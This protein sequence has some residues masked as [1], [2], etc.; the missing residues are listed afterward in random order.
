MSHRQKVAAD[1]ETFF[2]FPAGFLAK[3][4]VWDKVM[5]TY[6]TDRRDILGALTQDLALAREAGVAKTTGGQSF[7]M[8]TSLLK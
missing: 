5:F 3:G 4:G 7:D 1:L 6:S 2:K 8:L